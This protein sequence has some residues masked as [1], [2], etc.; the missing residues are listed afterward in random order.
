MHNLNVEPTQIS[1]IAWKTLTHKSWQKK[2]SQHMN[3]IQDLGWIYKKITEKMHV[4]ED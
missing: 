1:S 4:F 2:K 3:T